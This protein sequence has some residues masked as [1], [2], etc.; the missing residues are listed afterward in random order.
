MKNSAWYQQLWRKKLDEHSI[1][2]SAETSWAGMKDLLDKQMPANPAAIKKPGK[3][4]GSTIISTLG[5]IL[6]AA[7]MIAGL[8]FVAI[9]HNPFKPEQPAKTRHLYKIK[10]TEKPIKADSASIDSLSAA[11]STKPSNQNTASAEKIINAESKTGKAGIPPSAVLKGNS[12]T[13]SKAPIFTAFLFSGRAA[14]GN[15]SKSAGKEK[16][17]NALKDQSPNGDKNTLLASEND[18]TEQAAN[19]PQVSNNTIDKL[20]NEVKAKPGT[21]TLKNEKKPHDKDSKA[22]ASS[23]I[24][25]VKK[26]DPVKR[27]NLHNGNSSYE[28]GIESGLNAG[29]GGTNATF[30]IWG[31]FA[32]N[33]KWQIITGIRYDRNMTLQG[34]ITHK[35]FA[36]VDSLY[37]FK[38]S[39]S[40]KISSI[41]IPVTIAYKLTDKVSLTG[42]PLIRYSASQSKITNKLGTVANIRDTISKSNA[43]DSLLQF[44][45]INKVTVGLAAGVSI[46]LNRFYIDGRLQQNITPYKV[47]TGLGNFQQNYRSFQ[48]GIRYTIKRK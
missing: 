1:K 13:A 22:A 20:P 41:T 18:Q 48:I 46:R 21:E 39:N 34:D 33:P 42:G 45:S 9:K 32:L 26:P 11:Y 2:E 3:F 17:G 38:V 31:S 19:Q 12:K 35:S 23:K 36:P 24:K 37:S 44:N 4:L 5:F 30:G 47:N 29:K 27:N 40:R 8:T 15:H 43:I 28:I 14:K 6:P 7:A 10:T 25:P 16:I